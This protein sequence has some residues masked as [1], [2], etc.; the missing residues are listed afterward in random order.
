MSI[1]PNFINPDRLSCTLTREEAREMLGVSQSS[2]LIGT[3][4]T[5]EKR[6]GFEYLAQAVTK[7]RQSGENVQLLSVG[8]QEDSYAQTIR[9]YIEEHSMTEHIMLLGRRSDIPQI[10]KGIDCACLPS[11]REVMPISLLESMGAGVPALATAVGGVPECIRS[12]VDGMLVPPKC[13]EALMRVI[14]IWIDDPEAVRRM[15]A[16][17]KESMRERFAPA[18]LV[19]RIVD[20]Y[21]RYAVD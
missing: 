16:Q 3:I 1:I 4:G 14:K 9:Q 8:P 21:Q 5:L 18:A 6:K 2:F 19:P 7:L 20:I 13:A 11:L 15:G 10:L 12:D 17:A